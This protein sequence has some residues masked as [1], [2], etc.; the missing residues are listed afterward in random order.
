MEN[1]V[2]WLNVTHTYYYYWTSQL[3]NA[4]MYFVNMEGKVRWL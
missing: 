4:K 2:S 3:Y 1:S